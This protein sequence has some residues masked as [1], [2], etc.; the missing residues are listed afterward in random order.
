MKA[1]V[2]FNNSNGHYL[3]WL[4]KRNFRH[5]FVCVHKNGLWLLV[6]GKIGVPDVRYLCEDD[7]DLKGFY[8]EKGYTVVETEQREKPVTNPLILRNC[9]GVVKAILCISGFSFTPYGLYRKL[10]N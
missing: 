6:D 9:V 1:L 7:F 3:S 2:I 10:R 4:L 8:E 5:C